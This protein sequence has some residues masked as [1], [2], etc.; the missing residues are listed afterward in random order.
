MPTSNLHGALTGT[1]A[2]RVNPIEVAAPERVRAAQADLKVLVERGASADPSA[3]SRTKTELESRIRNRLSVKAEVEMLP[4]E[5]FER[6]GA[7]KIS[8]TIRER[9]VL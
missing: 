8:L 6:P 4:Y 3:D 9:P 2:T 7:R 5:A 1:S